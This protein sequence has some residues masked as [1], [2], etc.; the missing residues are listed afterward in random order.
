MAVLYFSRPAIKFPAALIAPIRSNS[1]H[2]RKQP[3]NSVTFHSPHGFAAAPK[4]LSNALVFHHV[5]AQVEID[6]VS[7]K[8]RVTIGIP[9][10]DLGNTGNA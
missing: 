10:A 1:Q 2:R 9:Y 7:S 6:L 4:T 8:A 5:S 3:V